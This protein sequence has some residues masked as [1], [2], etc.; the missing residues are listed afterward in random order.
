MNRKLCLMVC[1]NLRPEIEKILTDGG[2]E[3][4]VLRGFP[5]NCDSG[6]GWSAVRQILKTNKNG[7]GKVDVIGGGCLLNIAQPPVDLA[8]VRVH[9]FDTC[10]Q[11]FLPEATVNH[12]VGQG[13][14]LLTP[15]WLAHWRDQIS[16]WGFDRETAAE[17]FGEFS[18]KLLL[19]DTGI[20]PESVAQLQAFADFLSLPAEV[21]P[22]GLEWLQSLVA[23]VVDEWR[24]QVE[25]ENRLD[26]LVQASRQAT[27]YAMAL[28]W[29]GNLPQLV[30]EE[31]V[32]EQILEFFAGLFA[33][34]RLVFVSVVDNKPVEARVYP[35]SQPIDIENVTIPDCEY[36]WAED[37]RGFSVKI[38][39]HGK[40][41]GI[42]TMEEFSFPEYR[43]QYLNLALTLVKVCGLAIGNTRV[44]R[45]V[46]PICANCKKIRNKKN[47][48]Q[49]VDLYIHQHSEI[50]FTHGLCPE[51]AAALY[52]DFFK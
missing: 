26:P 44:L 50:D 19:L 12:F 29:I 22:V 51:C 3:D 6:I 47:Q 35:S 10:F 41:V 52:P 33:P 36:G 2:F 38:D 49:P 20:N 43:Q 30:T 39:H 24:S 17:F 28:D 5:A 14:Y 25:W 48:W 1:N 7:F 16:T 42:M 31:A 11:F 34:N 9:K 45:G 27:D 15:G 46:L 4:V 18:S 40:I 32:I 37:E 13:A 23:T 21:L 8:H